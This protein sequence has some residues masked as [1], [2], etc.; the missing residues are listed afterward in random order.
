MQEYQQTSQ[1]ESETTTLRHV[2]IWRRRVLVLA[3]YAT[4]LAS[5][6]LLWFAGGLT[7]APVQVIPITFLLPLADHFLI[8]ICVPVACMFFCYLAL[9]R[10]TGEIMSTPVRHLDERQRMIRNRTH[11]S[12]FNIIKCA[13]LLIPVLFLLPHLPW[14]NQ[15]YPP[16]YSLTYAL[17]DTYGQPISGGPMPIDGSW[18]VLHM[19]MI[20]LAPRPL[21]PAATPLE[22]AVA[23]AVLLFCLFLMISALPRSVLLWKEKSV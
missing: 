2:S 9:R 15:I 11:R 4:G 5:L 3:F 17:L 7:D 22:I 6:T 14:F 23:I 19:A 21:L 1:P 18:S 8:L 16:E 20:T 13:C 12:A 10:L